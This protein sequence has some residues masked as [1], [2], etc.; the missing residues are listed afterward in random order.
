MTRRI[1][2]Y[3]CTRSRCTTTEPQM[4]LISDSNRRTEATTLAVYIPLHMVRM[5]QDLITDCA[6]DT[7]CR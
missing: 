2:M 3:M 1:A 7:V 6:C 4:V 5:D